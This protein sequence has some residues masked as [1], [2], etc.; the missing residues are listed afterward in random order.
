VT[1]IAYF[2]PSAGVGGNP[3]TVILTTTF[4]FVAPLGF[5]TERIRGAKCASALLLPVRVAG[6]NGMIKKSYVEK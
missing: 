6:L 1:E 4:V 2:P 3:G 5:G